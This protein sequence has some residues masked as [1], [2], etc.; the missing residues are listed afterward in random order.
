[1]DQSTA[2]LVAGIV[3]AI[4]AVIH[5]LRLTFKFEVRVG[6]RLIPLW[7]NWV[8]LVIAGILSIWM[9]LAM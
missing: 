7:M 5:I 2:L 6:G 8:G 1:M 3:F 4:V 9:F